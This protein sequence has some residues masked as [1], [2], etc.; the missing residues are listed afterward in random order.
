MCRETTEITAIINSG[1]YCLE[2]LQNSLHLL[3]QA[4]NV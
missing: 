4:S 3:I 2:E 1:L